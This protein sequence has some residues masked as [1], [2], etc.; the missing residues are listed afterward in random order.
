MKTSF[1]NRFF[2]RIALT[3]A[4]LTIGLTL[5]PV[6][7]AVPYFARKYDV[8]CSRC[9]LLPPMLNEFGQRFVANGYKLRELEKKAPTIPVAMWVTH[10]VEVDEENERAKGYF[11]R[12]EAISSDAL[13]PWLSYFVEWRPLS[14]QTT[15]SQKLLGRH[16]RFEDLFIQFWLP[17]RIAITVGQF[18]MLNQWDV[19]RRLTLSEPL[20]FSA[21]VAGKSSSNSRLGSLRSFS[22]AGRAPAVRATFQ[23]LSGGSESDGWFHELV[24][25]LS[26]ELTLPLG[27]EAKRNAS[28]E[29]EGR[30][31]GFL[32][33]TYYRKGLSSIGG[34]FFRGDDRW[35][36]NLTS[37]LQLGRH[38]FMGS[39]GTARFRTG[40][41]DFR[42][43]V[44]DN[45]IPKNWLGLGARLDHQSGIR[46]RPALIPH[47]NFSFP[48]GKY[49]F[50]FTIEQRIQ[51]RNYNTAFEFGA[52]F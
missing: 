51:A 9:H 7:Q 36:S 35:L 41:H 42:L 2:S 32:Y 12:V 40:V 26:G 27:Q 48:S 29:L 37:T 46:R 49:T 18:R 5:A 44:G 38:V 19:S 20:A 43:S 13:A 8:R 16:G 10:R 39:A 23:T 6:S 47:L 4:F 22:L 30:L 15:S 24:L 31:K 28:F 3:L 34:T 25:P 33:E 50:L 17:Q 45:W 11:N 21:G 14:Y 52:V 1:V